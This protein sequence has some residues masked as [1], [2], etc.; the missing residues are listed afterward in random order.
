MVDHRDERQQHLDQD[1]GD[2][3]SLVYGHPTRLPG[4]AGAATATGPALAMLLAGLD[5]ERSF[6]ARRSRELADRADGLTCLVCGGR[7]T[8]VPVTPRLFAH[9]ACWTAQLELWLMAPADPDT[10]PESGEPLPF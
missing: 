7:G 2:V 5:T 9:R 8:M 3:D 4:H 6:L 1:G 10:A